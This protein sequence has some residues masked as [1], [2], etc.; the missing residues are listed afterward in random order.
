MIIARTTPTEARSAI[1][2]GIF[3]GEVTA[4][5]EE[6]H[7]RSRMVT[8]SVVVE[9]RRRLRIYEPEGDPPRGFRGVPPTLE[10]AYLVM[11]RMVGLSGG[12]VPTEVGAGGS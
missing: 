4:E 12:I 6:S 5:E 10:D 3:E 8:Q 7:H 1:D 11:M 9:G 2:G